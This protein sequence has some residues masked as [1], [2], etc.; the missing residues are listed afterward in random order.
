MVNAEAQVRDEWGGVRLRLVLV[1]V[2]ERGYGAWDAVVQAA[3]SN[4]IQLVAELDSAVRYAVLEPPAW[5]SSRFI[6]IYLPLMGCPGP[7]AA[8][9]PGMTSCLTRFILARL[10]LFSV[11]GAALSLFLL[12]LFDGRIQ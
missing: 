10:R 4:F 6:P 8:W 1:L 9:I 11:I 12:A 3:N 2:L 5:L 7:C